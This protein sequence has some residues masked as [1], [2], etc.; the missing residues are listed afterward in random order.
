MDSIEHIQTVWFYLLIGLAAALYSTVGQGGGSG[1]LAVMALFALDPAV[2]KPAALS[3]NVFVTSIVWWRAHRAGVFRWDL[4]WPFVI[5][6]VPL[7]VVGGALT[8]EATL[9]R[10]LV[11][12]ALLL[13]ALRLLFGGGVMDEIKSPRR[14]L[15][16]WAGGVL[17][18]LAG[19]TG[20]GG[21]IFLSPLLVYLRWCTMPQNL[22][23]SAAFIWINSV[24]ALSGYTV[25]TPAWPPGI[26]MMVVAAV[27]GTLVGAWVGGRRASPLALRRLLG[28]VLVLTAL[29]MIIT[30]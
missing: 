18:L 27:A 23:V 24:A 4:L 29:R 16:L 9:Y 3:M 25:T 26:P 22:A 11:G 5:T 2:M 7:A 30:M 19:L 10:V 6:S 1:Y 20:V 12:A 13:A 14:G 28:L 8:L 21:G 17:G 15:S